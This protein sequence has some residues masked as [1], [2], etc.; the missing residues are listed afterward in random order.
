MLYLG[1]GVDKSDMER[2]VSKVVLMGVE[3]NGFGVMLGVSGV[4][5]NVES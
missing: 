4:M 5:F 2:M 1:G 3:D